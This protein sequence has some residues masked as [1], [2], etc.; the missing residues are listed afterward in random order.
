MRTFVDY[1]ML[2]VGA[3]LVALALELILAPNSLVDGGTTALSIM[4]AKLFG[5][6]I[7]LFL[8]CLNGPILVISA[9]ALGKTFAWRTGYSNAVALLGLVMLRDVPAVTTSEVLIVLYGGLLLGLG[10]GIVVRNG[11]AIDG[12]EML[13]VWA[14]QRFNI[15][16]STFLLSINVV[17]LSGAAL[18]FGLESAMFSVAV[19]F[20]V[21]K[22]IDFVLEGFNQVVSVMIISDNCEPVRRK[23]V[24][25]MKMRVTLLQGV[26]GYSGEPRQII[27][28]IIDRFSYAR[29]RTAVHEVDP[30]AILE[31]SIVNESAGVE[32]RALRDIVADRYQERANGKG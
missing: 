14:N 23:L 1:L 29:L 16:V 20:L 19:F 5:L 25:E 31:A 18:V 8:L 15:P 21:T 12:T 27:Y 2:T 10:V 9:R 30:K 6:P 28:C 24:E 3:V 7:W 17:I 22:V 11:G 26:G 4:G 13:A 32:A